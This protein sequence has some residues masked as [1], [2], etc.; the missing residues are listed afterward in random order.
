MS[1]GLKRYQQQLSNVFD[2]DGCAMNQDCA[3]FASHWHF[4]RMDLTPLA[5]GTVS[6]DPFIETDY[7]TAP[8][9]TWS[10]WYTDFVLVGA[11]G[12]VHPS[13]PAGRRAARGRRCPPGTRPAPVG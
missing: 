1:G 2:Q 8:N 5:G 3:A 13:S 10:V 6:G 4:R 11:D 12:T 9:T 7:T